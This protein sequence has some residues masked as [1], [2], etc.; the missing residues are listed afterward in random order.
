M[1]IC[2]GLICGN[3]VV[4]LVCFRFFI[5]GN[6]GKSGWVICGISDE[7]DIRFCLLF[8]CVFDCFY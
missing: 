2:L 6:D 3:F 5:S 7:W 4:R 8:V 1:L